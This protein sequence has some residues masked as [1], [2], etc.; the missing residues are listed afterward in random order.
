MSKRPSD[1]NDINKVYLSN[2][3]LSIES[4]NRREEQSDCWRQHKMMK[5]LKNDDSATSINHMKTDTIKSTS[6]VID[7]VSTIDSDNQ[8]RAL[9]AAKKSR[10]MFLDEKEQIANISPV[11]NVMKSTEEKKK[12]KDKKEKKNKKEKKSKKSKKESK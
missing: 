4:H 6:G 3:I 7:K 10:K 12:K 11:E 2:T 8:E 9:W 1:I 5:K